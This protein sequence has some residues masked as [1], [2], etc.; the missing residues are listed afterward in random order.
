[1]RLLFAARSRGWFP[2]PCAAISLEDEEEDSMELEQ[3]PE[4]QELNGD[5]ES[6]GTRLRSARTA[7]TD[8]NLL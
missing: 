2:R 6:V 8:S 4:A 5:G 7:A 3:A 1:M